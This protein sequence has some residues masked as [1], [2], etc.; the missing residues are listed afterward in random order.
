MR[1][2]LWYHRGQIPFAP[3]I[4]SLQRRKAMK[5]RLISIFLTASMV[6]S[7]AVG[8]GGKEDSGNAPS[9]TD[10]TES[11]DKEDKGNS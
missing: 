4:M 2:N 10:G 9:N 8:C 1:S 11:T 7:M 6:A 3:D 5:K